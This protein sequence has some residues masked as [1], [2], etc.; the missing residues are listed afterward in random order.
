[1]QAVMYGVA[2]ILAGCNWGEKEN[3]MRGQV[4]GRL[5]ASRS[6]DVL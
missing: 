1:M 6:D 3:V 2:T 5:W 4:S